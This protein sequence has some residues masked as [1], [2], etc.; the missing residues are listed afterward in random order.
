MSLRNTAP[1]VGV[2]RRS[3]LFSDDLDSTPAQITDSLLLC[4]A[5]RVRMPSRNRR[6]VSFSRGRV[7][8]ELTSVEEEEFTV[9][10][11]VEWT[12]R[13][14]KIVE[15][16][17]QSIAGF[18]HRYLKSVDPPTSPVPAY[19]MVDFS[20]YNTRLEDS[21]GNELEIVDSVVEVTESPKG[22]EGQPRFQFKLSFT[23]TR[24]EQR[25]T[26]CNLR[27]AYSS[28]VFQY[29][30]ESDSADARV[31]VVDE[32]PGAEPKGIAT[33]VNHND[34]VFTL[35]LDG[36]LIVYASGAFYEIDYSYAEERIADAS[37]A[38]PL[39][40]SVTSEKGRPA[41]GAI[42]WPSKTVFAIID[43]RKNGMISAEFGKADL[44]ICDDLGDEIA[45]FIAVDFRDHRI[46]L[47]HAKAGKS[48]FSASALHEVVSQ[49]LKNLSFLAKRRDPPTR[50]SNW[51]RSASWG[52]NI[53]RWR[54]GDRRL[55]TGS[56]LWEKIRRE[57]IDNPQSK[58]E[59]WLVLGNI[60]Q[61]QRLL[62]KLGAGTRDNV[63]GQFVY[64]LSSLRSTCAQHGAKVRI[65][66]N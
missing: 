52:S 25:R 37:R 63:T 54:H 45:D 16:T 50:V 66:C 47:I 5:A 40:A 28:N 32:G 9:Q 39:L 56:R 60:L 21:D 33:Y 19:A 59:V 10:Q 43:N 35:I 44:V 53:K 42:A 48:V 30:V 49:A 2:V 4:T 38:Y 41:R 23:H 61:R 29:H 13:L 11:Y 58:I 17:K 20:D 3:V 65:F 7:S 22:K 14:A 57:V 36:G 27:L 12:A 46:A 8:D 55:P 62:E 18:F 34:D 1:T 31:F 51:T 26:E 6:Y 15:D 24:N 64:L